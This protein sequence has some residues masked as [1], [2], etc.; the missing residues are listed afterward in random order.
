MEVVPSCK[1]TTGIWLDLL[2]QNQM[3]N[4]TYYSKALC[5]S[6]RVRLKIE[7]MKALKRKSQVH[8]ESNTPIKTASSTSSIMHDKPT[9]SCY[10]DS[11][12]TASDSDIDTPC[13]LISYRDNNKLDKG[14]VQK[15]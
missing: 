8:P 12:N 4:A 6:Q 14:T 13:S 9:L 15:T 5:R 10:T 11:N 1:D 2:E 7:K 3:K